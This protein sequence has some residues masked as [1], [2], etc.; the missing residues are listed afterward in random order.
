MKPIRAV[1]YGL[2]P[3]GCGV[4]KLAAT[5]QGI[6][7]VGGVDINPQISGRDLGEVIGLDKPLGIAVSDDAVGLLAATRPDIVLHCTSSS[8]RAVLPQLEGIIALGSNVIST[9]EEL[10]FPQAQHPDLADRLDRLAKQHGV[11]VLGTGI[12]P[13]F[14]MDTLPIAVT[15]VCQ[16]VESIRV[17]R[18]V[19]AGERR[20]P[21]QKKVGAGLTRAAFD[22]LVAAGRVRHVG[23]EESARMVASALGWALDDYQETIEP[24][25]AERTLRSRYLEVQPG[26]V[27]GVRQVGVG[28]MGG[29]AVITLELRMHLGAGRSVDAIYV[30]GTPPLRMTMEGVHGDLATAAMVVNAI[31]RVISAPAGLVTMK[32]LPLTHAW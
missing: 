22:E 30:E 8:L 3:I 13:G 10:S 27:A 11:T 17:E 24:V 29:N 14:I 31:P 1:Q 26:Q 2:G 19:D 9:T 5:R 16:T 21:L 12:N 18:V 6:E 32:D 20:L 15:A 7:L 4:A 28:R 23:L 25:I